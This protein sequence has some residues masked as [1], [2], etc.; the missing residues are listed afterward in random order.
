MIEGRDKTIET[1]KP[2]NRLSLSEQVSKHILAK[3]SSG[4]LLPGDRVVEA[5]ICQELHVSSIPVREAIRELVANHV[6]EYV[7]HRGAQVREVSMGETIDALEVK[8]VL[9]PLAANLAGLENLTNILPDLHKYIRQIRKDLEQSDYIHF[10]LTNQEFHKLIVESAHNAILLRL[11]EEMA[12]DIRTKPLM[13]YLKIA[14]PEDLIEEHQNII[15]A[16]EKKDMNEV[17]E[18]LKIHSVHLADHLKQ[19]IEE[20]VEEAKKNILVIHKRRKQA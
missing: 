15:D 9:E 11:W 6:L 5:Q 4:K 16:I 1:Y 20:N 13:D 12:F 3:I 14:D 17:S 10:Q 19:K 7:M 8:A 18:K 2:A